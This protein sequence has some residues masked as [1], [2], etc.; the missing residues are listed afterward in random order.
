MIRSLSS[1]GAGSVERL[2][3]IIPTRR[4]F[5]LSR[6]KGH[7]MAWRLC[8]EQASGERLWHPARDERIH[9]IARESQPIVCIRDRLIAFNLREKRG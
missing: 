6:I 1:A 3:I 2:V 5:Y 9:L 4:N 8:S 7:L